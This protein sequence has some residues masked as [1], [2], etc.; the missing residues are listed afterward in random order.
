MKEVIQ[1]LDQILIDFVS[2]MGHASWCH[3]S[4]RAETAL[5]ECVGMLDWNQRIFLPMK[6][7]NRAGHA[8]HLR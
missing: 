4:A 5:F 2:I 3:E 7:E 1:W 6:D 8:M